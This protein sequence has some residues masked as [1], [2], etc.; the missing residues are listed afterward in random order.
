M[1]LP[2]HTSLIGIDK[3][4]AEAAK[5]LGASSPV[6]FAKVILPL[7]L[8]GIISGIIMVFIPTISSFAISEM[9]GGEKFC[10]LVI[11]LMQK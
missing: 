11:Q 2:I 3:S 8:P 9:L 10:Y 7:T 1:I 5:D 4:Y 6:S